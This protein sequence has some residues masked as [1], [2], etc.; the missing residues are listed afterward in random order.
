MSIVKIKH[1]VFRHVEYRK[2][3]SSVAFIFNEIIAEKVEIL[4]KLNC[5]P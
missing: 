5:F 2:A 1:R 4:L 3:V